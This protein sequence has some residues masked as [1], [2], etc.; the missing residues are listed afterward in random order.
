MAIHKAFETYLRSQAIPQHAPARFGLSGT[1]HQPIRPHADRPGISI[2]SIGNALLDYGHEA[3][4]QAERALGG[5]SV[6]KQPA[7]A[8]A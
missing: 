7:R 3:L 6:I 4:R 2:R 8:D 5:F 1:H